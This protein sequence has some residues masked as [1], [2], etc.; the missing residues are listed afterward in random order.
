[1]NLRVWWPEMKG[2]FKFESGQYHR[3][4]IKRKGLCLA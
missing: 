3:H 4:I 1:M 2:I